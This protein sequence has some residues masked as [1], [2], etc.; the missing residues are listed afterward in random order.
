MQSITSGVDTGKQSLE[1]RHI[2]TAPGLKSDTLILST[3]SIGPMQSV[4]NAYK[5][6]CLC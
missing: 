3:I 6:H 5:F 2:P 4:Y 1:T